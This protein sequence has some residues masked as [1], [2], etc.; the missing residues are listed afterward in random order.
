LRRKVINDPSLK[1]DKKTVRMEEST[2]VVI[3]V[4]V[5]IAATSSAL[6][7]RSTSPTRISETT[8]SLEYVSTENGE[9][10][11]R[12]LYGK[13]CICYVYKVYTQFPILVR[14]KREIQSALLTRP[15]IPKN[16]KNMETA[17][18]W[19]PPDPTNCTP[20]SYGYVTVILYPY[21]NVSLVGENYRVGQPGAYIIIKHTGEDTLYDAFTVTPPGL[22]NL[23]IRVNKGVPPGNVALNGISP[24][25][26]TSFE[27]GDIL[28]IPL[29]ADPDLIIIDIVWEP[30]GQSLLHLAFHNGVLLDVMH[31]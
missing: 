21:V 25:N 31:G 14:E 10:R 22:A 27:P 11:Y 29:P 5:A 6:I 30:S 7:I 1:T 2:A 3:I 26:K 13:N 20:R 24:P 28:Q 9:N 17:F 4:V 19:D 18:E 12:L 23:T 15:E 8:F 16:T